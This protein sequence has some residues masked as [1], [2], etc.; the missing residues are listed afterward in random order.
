MRQLTQLGL[1]VHAITVQTGY[2][3]FFPS[4][5]PPSLE[6]YNVDENAVSVSGLS[7]GASMAV[8]FHAAFS[9]RVM[10]LGVM[11]G[12]PYGCAGLTGM[13]IPLCTLSPSLIN[14]QVLISGTESAAV[15][16]AIDNTNNTAN[17]KIFIYNGLSDS[18]VNSD[19]GQKLVEFYQHFTS[20][21][22]NIMTKLDLDAEHGVPTLQY[23]GPC[24]SFNPQYL[25]NCNYWTAYHML[26]HIY[27]GQLQE[28]TASTTQSGQFLQFDQSDMFHLSTPGM[29]S[30]DTIGY[31]YVPSGCADKTT[32]CK[33]HIAFHGCQ[34][35]RYFIGNTFARHAGYNEVGELN[36]ILILYPQVISSLTNPLG[37]WDW[38]GYT[39]IYYRTQYGFQMTA[40]R[41]MMEA[42]IG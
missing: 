28:P 16:G 30:M 7:S 23:G 34:Q 38:W 13:T 36:N 5:G 24:T 22:G 15:I 29:Y 19:V 9:S 33:L 10:G 21:Q 2:C 14:T 40:V 8:Q 32:E 26:N 17:D 6:S 27:G 1:L 3:F 18:V 4:F 20:N 39:G 25:L 42:V 41:R 12:V 35:G 37:C 31:I 11:A